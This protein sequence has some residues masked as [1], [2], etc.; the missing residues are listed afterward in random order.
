LLQG[1]QV[2]GTSPD[3]TEWKRLFNALAGARN[4]H[5]VGNPLIMFINHAMPDVR[6]WRCV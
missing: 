5:L 3:M 6:A 4:Q 2:A 1:I